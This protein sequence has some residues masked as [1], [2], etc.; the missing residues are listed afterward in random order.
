MGGFPVV[1]RLSVA[2]T[3]YDRNVR[4][5]SLD[6]LERA[7]RAAGSIKDVADLAEILELRKR[8]PESVWRYAAQQRS[9]A[10]FNA[11]GKDDK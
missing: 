10:G 6:G 5:L 2:M 9:S 4:V 1:R 7:K 11:V 8:Q 3:V